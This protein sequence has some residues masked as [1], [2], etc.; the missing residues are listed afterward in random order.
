MKTSIKYTSSNEV[1]LVA[2]DPASPFEEQINWVF[3]V[4]HSGGYVRWRGG[5]QVCSGL[6][7][8]GNSLHCSDP[9]YL[10]EM[11]RNEWA[12]YRRKHAY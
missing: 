5:N 6:E 11:I 4:P 7:R 9:K 12:K 1:T 2:L 3:F 8:T 10:L